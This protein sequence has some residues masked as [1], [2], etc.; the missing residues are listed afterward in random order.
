MRRAASLVNSVGDSD[1]DRV[2][3]HVGHGAIAT[4]RRNILH[5]LNNFEAL[6]NL[7]EQC[8]SRRQADTARAADQEELRTVG[9][10]SGVSHRE[11]TDLVL[12]GLGQFVSELVARSA[13]TSAG[14]VATLANET[15]NDAVEDDAVVVVVQR[16]EDE[17]VHGARGFDGVESDDHGAH[18]GF[19]GGCV[20]L[21]D[22]D[23]HFGLRRELLALGGGSVKRGES[24]GHGLK[25]YL[26]TTL[27]PCPQRNPPTKNRQRST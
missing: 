1:G 7:T 17:A 19:H 27:S 16:Q 6:H 5:G 10:G 14:R 11:G 26:P 12:T 13:H 18:R 3:H 20:S 24:C 4:C 8:I 22:V 25:H 21:G 15:L 2:D 23:T 9:V